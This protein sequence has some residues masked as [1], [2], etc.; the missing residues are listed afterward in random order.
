MRRLKVKG[1]NRI[2][3]RAADVRPRATAQRASHRKPRPCRVRERKRFFAFD[4]VTGWYLSSR[5]Y[6]DGWDNKGEENTLSRRSGARSFLSREEAIEA[7]LSIDGNRDFRF[8]FHNFVVVGAGE[9]EPQR[10]PFEMP[11]EPFPKRLTLKM[12]EGFVTTTNGWTKPR[13]GRING[14]GALF[15]AK[16]A[17]HT[18]LKHIQNECLTHKLYRHCGL[19][20]PRSHIYR[21]RFRGGKVDHVLLSEYI[22]GKPLGEYL[23]SATK[24]ELKHIGEEVL[25]SF[26]LDSFLNNY[27][28]YNNDNSIVDGEGRLWHVDNGSSLRFR[29]TGGVMPWT[30]AVG[31]TN[32][33]DVRNGVYCM[34]NG[35]CRCKSPHLVAALSN[36]AKEDI[37]GCWGRF[38]FKFA[39]LVRRFIPKGFRPPHIVQYAQELDRLIRD[40][41]GR[42]EVPSIVESAYRVDEEG[43]YDESKWRR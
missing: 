28:A 31:R 23:K 9:E 34:Y 33:L 32:P 16:F 29:A 7:I 26:P 42:I 5:P 40:N 41:G 13:I 11:E 6:A 18:S 2:Q 22:E 35:D 39:N 38:G 24:E 12:L 17:S 36:V 3:G 30:I 43:N 37:E 1:L 10:D 19:N 25:R 20:A 4:T 8:P 15:V 27:D 14:E 21:V